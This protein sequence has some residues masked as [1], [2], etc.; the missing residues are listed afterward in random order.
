[1]IFMED[2][3]FEAGKRIM[4]RYLKLQQSLKD[5]IIEQDSKPQLNNKFI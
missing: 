5:M 3:N 1:M 2:K 4:N